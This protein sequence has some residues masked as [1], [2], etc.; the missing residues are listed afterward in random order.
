M[1]KEVRLTEAVNYTINEEGVI[2]N[3]VAKTNVTVENGKVKLMNLGKRKEYD[4]EELKAKYFPTEKGAEPSEDKKPKED[5][6]SKSDKDHK[7][8]KKPKDEKK[9]KEQ[10]TPAVVKEV[11]LGVIATILECIK[12]GPTTEAAIVKKLVESFP[13]KVEASLANTVRAQIGSSKRPV[14]MEKE[15]E[16]TFEIVVDEKT[17]VKT[18]SI[19][20]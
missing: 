6:K 5:K 10:K 14:R 18:Y 12:T 2:R 11:K 20:S 15:K 3:K 13:E 19:K 8:D 9:P 17:K 1:S 4:V 16:V 7:E